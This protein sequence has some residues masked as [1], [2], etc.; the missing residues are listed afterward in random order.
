[1]S[2]LLV[3]AAQCV[4][5]G[6][7]GQATRTALVLCGQIVVG[8]AVLH[9]ALEGLGRLWEYGGEICPL[10]LQYRERVVHA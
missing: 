2:F 1:M 9:E 8:V 3:S 7:F 4:L 5:S 6:G 10:G